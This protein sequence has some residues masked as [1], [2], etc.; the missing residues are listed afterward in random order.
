[1]SKSS[2][3]H[4]EA[5]QLTYVEHFKWA[6]LSGFHLIYLGIASIFHAFVPSW[7]EG[8]SAKAIIK[9]FYRHLYNHPNPDY[10]EMIMSEFAR[11]IKDDYRP[12]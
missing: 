7:F 5:S 3:E 8:T 10:R 9:I 2:K 12:K 1:M 6:F 4:L 11:T